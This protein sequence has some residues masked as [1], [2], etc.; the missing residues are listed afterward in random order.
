MADEEEEPADAD[1]AP[2]PAQPAWQKHA[3]CAAAVEGKCYWVQQKEN[4]QWAKAKD[5]MPDGTPIAFAGQHVCGA[6]ACLNAGGHFRS[7]A[8]PAAPAPPLPA[9]ATGM[10]PP[11]GSR[12]GGNR[13]GGNRGGGK[14]GGRGK[15]VGRGAF[16]IGAFMNAAPPAAAAAAGAAAYPGTPTG[17]TFGDDL[18]R[19]VGPRPV[20]QPPQPQPQQPPPA[21]APAPTYR[22]AAAP[23]PPSAPP[24]MM[25]AA[26]ARAAKWASRTDAAAACAPRHAVLEPPVDG[27]RGVPRLTMPMSTSHGTRT[28]AVATLT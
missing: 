5:K 4:F 16:G 9:I 18:C 15:G 13:G 12:G 17:L 27:E 20:P 26:T 3:R 28:L 22:S 8:K 2:A 19:P 14:G 25:P 11:A 1:A 24:P 21:A 23:A 6:P 7:R 10:L